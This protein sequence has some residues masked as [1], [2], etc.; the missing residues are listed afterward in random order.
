MAS[1]ERKYED[2][3]TWQGRIDRWRSSG[4]SITQFVEQES[5]PRSTFLKWRK[6]LGAPVRTSRGGRPLV[7]PSLPVTAKR[8]AAGAVTFLE[9][10]AATASHTNRGHGVPFEVGLRS[11]RRLQVPASFDPEVLERLIALLEVH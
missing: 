8:A 9:V 5:L 11:G 7:A 10:T 2:A 4:L 6:V 1:R 3:A